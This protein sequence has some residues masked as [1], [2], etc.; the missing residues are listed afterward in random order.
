MIPDSATVI[1]DPRDLTHAR[2]QQLS[3]QYPTLS[4]LC[5]CPALSAWTA[6]QAAQESA[7]LKERRK[8]REERALLKPEPKKGGK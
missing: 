3:H 4:H 2:L 6:Q 1:S 7:V 5:I 8:A